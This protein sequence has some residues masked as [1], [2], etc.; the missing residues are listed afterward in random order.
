MI[1]SSGMDGMLFDEDPFMTLLPL[2]MAW[3]SIPLIV[4]AILLFQPI[5]NYIAAVLFLP[6]FMGLN[7]CSY[8]HA[9]GV[10]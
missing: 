4:I 3:I 5:T 2:V 7:F 1:V 6:A 10:V 9:G 8:F